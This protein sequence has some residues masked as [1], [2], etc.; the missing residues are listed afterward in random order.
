MF[1]KTGQKPDKKLFLTLLSLLVFGWI[2]SFSASLGHFNS[3]GYFIKQ[4][5]YI[6]LGLSAGLLV[7]KV[8]LHFYKIH[9]WKLFIV[10]SILLFLVFLPHPIGW[11]VNGSRRWINFVFFKFQPSE[12]MKLAM[13][14]FMA[15]FLVDKQTNVRSPWL[16]LVQTLIIISFAAI[17]IMLETDLGA[18]I[19]ITATALG[20]LFSAGAYMM[21]FAYTAIAILSLA[22]LYIYNDPVRLSRMT[23][24]WQTEIW[25]N[26]SDKVH[27]TKQALI[28][29]ARGDW[30][31]TGLGA[32]IQ[33][34][35]KLPEA[36]TDMIFAII[37][38]ELGVVGMLAVL[39]LFAYVL[40]RGF[41]IAQ[42][43]LKDGRKYSS[44]VAFGI[45]TL[46]SLQISVN[47]AMNLALIPPKGFT[48]PLISYGGSS[49]IISIVAFA[50]L[51]RIDMESRVAH[52][53]RRKHY[54]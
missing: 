49:M 26:Q 10:S 28:G 35:S 9:A 34:Y 20:M 21:P 3:Y 29:I 44:Y 22:G 41:D 37:G 5:L 48:L 23:E 16:G 6:L 18:T 51:L 19:I 40:V 43:A 31:G 52:E 53:K 12:L 46:M 17:P 27:Q 25:L 15:K 11:E 32:G 33:K 36:H 50:I 47:I 2:M 30:T 45:C 1:D 54:L 8:P 39:I 24:F 42:S 14:L 7:L 13:I 4:T 38:E